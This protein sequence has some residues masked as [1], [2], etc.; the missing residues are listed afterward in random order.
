VGIFKHEDMLMDMS[1]SSKTKLYKDD[2][3]LFIG[4]GYKAISMMINNSKNQ[5]PVKEKFHKQLNMR[6]RPKFSKSDDIEAL[7]KQALDDH[8]KNLST[9]KK[10]SR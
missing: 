3:L 6:E 9:K 1:I 2:K 10:K 4:D 7:R 5:E 8:A